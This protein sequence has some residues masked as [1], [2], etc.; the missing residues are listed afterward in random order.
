MGSASPGRRTTSWRSTAVRSGLILL[1]TGFCALPARSA[2]FEETLAAYEDL[3]I[4]HEA[5]EVQGLLIQQ[6]HLRVNLASGSAATVTAAGKPIGVYF[7]GIG[8]F[9]YASEDS[10][11]IPVMSFNLKKATSLSGER[12]GPALRVEDAFEE[13]LILVAGRDAPKPGGSRAASLAE[14]F[15]AHRERFRRDAS[16]PASH[17]FVLR[18]IDAPDLPV[19]R[20]EMAGGKEDLVYLFDPVQT[21]TEWLWSLIKSESADTDLRRYRFPVILSGQPIDR[22]RRDPLPSR[23]DLTEVDYTLTASQ[24]SDVSITV[25]ET[26]VPAVP[27]RVLRF[28]MA[29]VI[30][31]REGTGSRSVE[32]RYHHVRSVTDAAGS[33]VPFHHDIGELIVGLPSAAAAGQPVR[34]RFEID[35]DFLIHPGH[36][37][38]WTLGTY[39]WFPQTEMGG[40]RYTVHS[41]VKAKKPW[42]PLASGAVVSRREEGEYKVVESRID[43]PVQF[44]VALAGNY[45]LQEETRNGLTIR[46]ASYAGMRTIAA[47]ELINLSFGIIEYYQ[48]FLGPFPFA[49]YQIIQIND[50]GWGQAPPA[51]MFITNEAFDS[52]T[53]TIA[54][55][56]TQGINERVA[57]EIAHQYWGH[58]VKMPNDE[59]QWLSEAFSEYCAALFLKHRVGKVEYNAALADW[60]I[61]GRSVRDVSTIPLANRLANRLYPEDAYRKR[62]YLIYQKGAWLLSRLHAELGDQTFLTF[63]KSYQKSYRWKFGS[64]KHVAGLL[65]FITKKSYMPFLQEYY[66]GTGMPD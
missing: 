31:T 39:P 44:T 16:A 36:D 6:G 13:A 38:Y 30:L 46:V 45:S 11:E 10:I 22:D 28:D 65:E 34:L 3:R 51:T 2:S 12:T 35:G 64:T 43:Q 9:T 54:W 41:V 14:R 42:T 47:K 48:S 60:K 53:D 15:A 61:N 4:A 1:F 56:Y 49:E 21:R 29:S 32:S 57:H 25:A 63:L 58:V 66:W 50:F 19:V 33:P 62:S 55:L 59:E 52:R 23:L 18:E 37:N 7:K 20:V 26:L 27:Q 40:Q 5:F 24:G 8:R 17:L